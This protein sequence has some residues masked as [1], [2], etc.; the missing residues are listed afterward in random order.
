MMHIHCFE[1]LDKTLRSITHVLK[2]F[3]GKVVV[4]GGDF[5][6][7]LPIVLKASRQDIVHATINSSQ[8]WEDC[9][10]LNLHTNMR[11]QSSSNPSEVEEVK[12]FADWILS[13]GN[14][15]AGEQNDGKAFVDISEDMLI[16]DSKYPLLNF[17]QFLYLDLLSIISNPDYFQGRAV[18]A[19]TNDCVEFVN[20]YLNSI[21]PGID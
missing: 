21:L 10:V 1:A 8:L 2:I 9:K 16:P 18:L 3:G 6:Q 11:L 7:I 12:E 4:L 14:G 19:P 17:S 20:D 15:E 5:R 13:I